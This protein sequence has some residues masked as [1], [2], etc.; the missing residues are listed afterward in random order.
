MER[1]L[2]KENKGAFLT[3]KQNYTRQV[4]P[5]SISLMQLRGG[6]FLFTSCPVL[7]FPKNVGPRLSIV[8]EIVATNGRFPPPEF[9]HST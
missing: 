6:F 7:P 4:T 9:P 3:Q 1:L 2:V 5:S 8:R